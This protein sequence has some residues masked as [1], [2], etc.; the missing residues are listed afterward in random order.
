MKLSIII[1][2]RGR[3]ASLALYRRSLGVAFTQTGHA[4][5]DIELTGIY[6]QLIAESG[7]FCKS[8]FL[9]AGI[10]TA[11]GNI[12]LFLDADAI[13][14]PRFFE[15]IHRLDDPTLTKLCYRVRRI[16]QTE[17][18][19]LLTEP[20]QRQF[21]TDIFSHYDDYP[22]AH[23]GYGRPT[24]NRPKQPR[25]P[26]FGNSQFAIR[27]ET[28][29][30]LRFDEEYVG[31]GYEDLDMNLRIWEKYGEAYR[32]EI[33]TDS[34][35]ALLH[36]TDKSHDAHWGDGKKDLNYQNSLRY[37]RKEAQCLQRLTETH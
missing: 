8:R 14:P 16:P 11:T 3:D 37:H 19:H 23:E 12:L 28:L 9:N 30:D 35:H 25:E 21:L 15:T 34:D 4:V 1:P 17:V 7:P 10:G 24:W 5:R 18:D 13:V 32:A 31:R 6:P 26:V 27:R 29:G 22:L 2:N 36:I 20:D 33:V